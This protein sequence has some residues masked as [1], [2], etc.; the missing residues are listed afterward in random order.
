MKNFKKAFTMIEL[1]VIIVVVGIL[2]A[3][4][5]PRV[6]RNTLLEAANQ[7]VSHI[8]YTQHLAMLDNKFDPNKKDWFKERW[9]IEFTQANVNGDSGWKY[10][11]YSDITKSGNLNSATEVAKDPQNHNKYLSAGWNGISSADAQ[12]INK[13]LN[14]ENQYGVSSVLFSDDCKKNGNISIS[15]D[16]KGRPYR[17]VSTIGGGAKDHIDRRLTVDCNITLSDGKDSAIITVHRETGY[18]ELVEFPK[19]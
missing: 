10:Q 18:V 14:I 16:E 6:E 2:A 1:I 15:F 8:R 3:V 4:V 19:L 13:N 12:R 7:V 17:K 11:V 9:T 5:V